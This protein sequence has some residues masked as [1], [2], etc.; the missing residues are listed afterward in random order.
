MYVTFLESPGHNES[1]D[2]DFKLPD[3]H[4]DD[5]EVQGHPPSMIKKTIKET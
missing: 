3:H 2:S 1:T 5:Q 4:Q